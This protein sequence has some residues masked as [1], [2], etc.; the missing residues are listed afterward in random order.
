MHVDSSQALCLSS[1]I[2]CV[3]WHTEYKIVENYVKKG[4]NKFPIGLD[5]EKY[6]K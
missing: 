6:K 1:K 3:S 5:L 2:M 4:Q